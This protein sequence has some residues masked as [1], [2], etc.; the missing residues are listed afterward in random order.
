MINETALAVMRPQPWVVTHG[1]GDN[2]RHGLG[3]PHELG[4]NPWMVEL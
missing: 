3:E 4:D 1:L 2:P